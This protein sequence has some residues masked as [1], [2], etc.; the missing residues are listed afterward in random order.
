MCTSSF[1][2]CLRTLQRVLN[3]IDVY[4]DGRAIE[5]DQLETCKVQLELVYRELIGAELL[6]EDVLLH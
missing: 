3:D 6:G 2:W 5:A 4:A 1:G